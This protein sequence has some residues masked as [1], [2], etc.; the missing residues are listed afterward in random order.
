M[1][2]KFIRRWFPSLY[3][4]R[5][6]RFSEISE[7][8]YISLEDYKQDILDINNE[9][10]EIELTIDYFK[11]RRR[12]LNEWKHSIEIKISKWNELDI[13]SNCKYCNNLYCSKFDFKVVGDATCEDFEWK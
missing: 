13:C 12:I 8:G 4:T 10:K 1:L 9:L 5:E 7:I 3:R 11:D 6:K 2:G